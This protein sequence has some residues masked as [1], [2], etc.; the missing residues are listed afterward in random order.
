MRRS[1]DIRD[2][3][4]AISRLRKDK[5]VVG[6]ATTSTCLIRGIVMDNLKTQ[7]ELLD[8]EDGDI[9]LVRAQVLTG[10]LRRSITTLLPPGVGAVFLGQGESMERADENDMRQAGWVR[11]EMACKCASGG[12]KGAT[13]TVSASH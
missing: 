1:Y 13:V 8:V 9:V 7:V 6:G 3:R 5:R 4:G 12:C 2:K 10:E 11:A